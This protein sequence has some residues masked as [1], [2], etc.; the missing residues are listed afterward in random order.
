MLLPLGSGTC[1][2][3]TPPPPACK[4]VSTIRLGRPGRGASYA[5]LYPH[6]QPKA[7]A[8]YICVGC[9]RICSKMAE[10]HSLLGLHHSEALKRRVCYKCIKVKVHFQRERERAF[11]KVKE[12]PLCFTIVFMSPSLGPEWGPD[13]SRPGPDAL[14]RVRAERCL[15]SAW[16]IFDLLIGRRQDALMAQGTGYIEAG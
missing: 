12:G 2:S 7:G 11:P 3:H 13:F 9:D 5:P 8:L 16:G 1:T 6:V 4:S 15:T 10:F 14:L